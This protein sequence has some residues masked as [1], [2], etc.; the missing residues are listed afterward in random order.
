MCAVFVRPPT[1]H[2]VCSAFFDN[3]QSGIVVAL[4]KF[5]VR[6]I[7]VLLLQSR[8]IA[9]RQTAQSLASSIAKDRN[10]NVLV[11]FQ[12]S[13][14]ERVESSLESMPK[15]WIRDIWMQSQK[16]CVDFPENSLRDRSVV[17]FYLSR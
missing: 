12:C 15:H 16:F 5:V 9:S 6:Q 7:R 11:A 10:D 14:P 3:A 8:Q 4:A 17:G 1:L 2:V 13:F